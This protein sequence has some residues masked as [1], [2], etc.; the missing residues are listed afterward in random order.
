[1]MEV[2]LNWL[3]ERGKRHAQ[4][5]TCLPVAEFGEGLALE[6]HLSE[7]KVYGEGQVL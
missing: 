7:M 5:I 6:E 3:F 4:K 2:R 1:M